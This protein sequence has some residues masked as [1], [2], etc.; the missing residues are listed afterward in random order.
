MAYNKALVTDSQI[1]Q[2]ENLIE[3]NSADFT[4]RLGE[5]PI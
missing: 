5:G 3:N 2:E 4:S 1:P